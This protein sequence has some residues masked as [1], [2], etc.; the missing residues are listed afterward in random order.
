MSRSL[1]REKSRSGVS[2]RSH[3]VYLIL[4]GSARIM[5]EGHTLGRVKPGGCVGEECVI[6]EIVGR[7][8]SNRAQDTCYMENQ[9]RPSYVLV[10]S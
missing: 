6:S 3:E 8:V 1:F 10:L 2:F 4:S 5:N 7:A 9:G